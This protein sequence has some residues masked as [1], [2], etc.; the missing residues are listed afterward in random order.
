[1]RKRFQLSFCQLLLLVAKELIAQVGMEGNDTNI[2]VMDLLAMYGN[3]VSAPLNIISHDFLILFKEAA[4]L[5]IIPSPTINHSMLGLVDKINGMPPLGIR[6][7]E[8]RSSTTRNA[9]HAAAAAAANLLTKQLNVAKLAVAQATTHLELMCANVEQACT[10][11][12]KVTWC[13]ATM[14]ESL[15]A[16]LQAQAATMDVVNVATANNAVLMAELKH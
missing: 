15:V 4:G 16:T 3:K 1:M 6:R 2:A 13:Q 14:H 8:V 12:K 7:Q 5:T 10:V 11:A 9:A